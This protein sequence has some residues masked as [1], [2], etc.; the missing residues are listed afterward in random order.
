[1]ASD[2]D[3]AAIVLARTKAALLR[4]TL[5]ITATA[6]LCA[7]M[8]AAEA[9]RASPS[10]GLTGKRKLELVLDALR[11]LTS[12]PELLASL[13]EEG[14]ARLVLAQVRGLL[15]SGVALE[16]IAAIASASAGELS[17]NEGVEAAASCFAFACLGRVPRAA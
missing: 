14:C 12:S 11:A 4:T 13:P 1:M 10:A 8:E 15:E 5:P 17:I 2:A 9:L 7:G 3:H 16:I 6:V